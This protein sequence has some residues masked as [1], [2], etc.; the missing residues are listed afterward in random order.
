MR[1]HPEDCTDVL[2][3][4]QATSFI[5][6]LQHPEGASWLEHTSGLLSEHKHAGLGDAV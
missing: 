4:S 1:L 3:Q 6:S 2:I 5:N